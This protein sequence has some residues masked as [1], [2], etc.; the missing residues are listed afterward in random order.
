MGNLMVDAARVKT[1][2][3][4]DARVVRCALR[5]NANAAINEQMIDE[6]RRNGG[7]ER[8]DSILMFN[9]GT[10]DA[11]LSF[12]IKNDYGIV[13]ELFPDFYKTWSEDGTFPSE[14]SIRN[15]IGG[16]G[17]L[18]GGRVY[19]S[20]HALTTTEAV[21]PLVKLAGDVRL[22][23][24]DVHISRRGAGY[25]LIK[26]NEPIAAKPSI[27]DWCP[28]SSQLFERDFVDNLM[29]ETRQVVIGKNHSFDE[30]RPLETANDPVPFG[31]SES[32]SDAL[33]AGKIDCM[34]SAC[35]GIGTI[36]TDRPETILGVGAVMTGLMHTAPNPV[37]IKRSTDLG[38]VVV[39]PMTARIDQVA[40]V[41]LALSR[42]YRKI[43][44]TVAGTKAE[45]I[46]KIVSLK[47]NHPRAEVSVI[48]V[49]TTNVN[50]EQTAL[51]KRHSDI[52]YACASGNIREA[53]GGKCSQLGTKIP[54]Y[55]S[56]KGEELVASR[57]AKMD[58][59]VGVG[60]LLYALQRGED[61]FFAFRDEEGG[62]QVIRIKP[63]SKLLEEKDQ[64][65]PLTF[66]D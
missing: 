43:A 57:L 25:V 32:M 13:R 44:V 2:G 35:E 64:P 34:V 36:I 29:D 48:T 26:D 30:K 47:E 7:Y 28:L 14:N 54:V 42:G 3:E 11:M 46:A 40:G 23:Y 65:R 61:R 12:E 62:K 24:P 5:K 49:C 33:R 15:I 60:S 4:T 59:D 63:I 58:S 16:K 18:D 50:K 38:D 45:D 20:N 66:R 39:H 52:T 37:L 6:L 1:F 56:K 51:I 31:A 21:R 10:G 27:V 41:K 8:G 17:T 19:A 53:F 22:L 9:Q 55:L